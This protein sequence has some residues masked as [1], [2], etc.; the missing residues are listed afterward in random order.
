MWAKYKKRWESRKISNL[1][2]YWDIKIQKFWENNWSRE[3]RPEEALEVDSLPNNL[4]PRESSSKKKMHMIK[5]PLN[6]G[7]NLKKSHEEGQDPLADK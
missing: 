1:L 4:E 6:R 3:L 5:L 7:T 2:L